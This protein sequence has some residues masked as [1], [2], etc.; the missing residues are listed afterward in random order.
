MRNTIGIDLG[1]TNIAAGAVSPDGRLLSRVSLSTGAD[2]PPEAV[3]ADMA[4]AARAAADQAGLPLSSFLGV[5]VGVP[6]VVDAQAGTVPFLPNLSWRHVP[7]AALLSR[8]LSLPVFLGNDADCAA[9]GEYT[10]GAG[11]QYSSLL[12][13]TLGTGLGGG[14]IHGGRIF[15]GFH[16]E[17]FEPGHVPFRF[18]GEVCG[19]GQRG[20]LEAY[21]SATALIRDTRR[22]MDAHPESALWVHAPSPALVTAK[23]PFDAAAKGDE[24]AEAVL[25]TYAA[26]LAAGLAGLV[27]VLRPEAVALGGG[28]ARQGEVLL[29]LIRGRFRRACFASDDIAPP[30]L[31]CA[32]L[33]NDAGIVGAGLL[34]R[35]V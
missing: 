22:A 15:S 19:C 17:G 13:I 28:V 5:G 1:G 29:S 7:L 8:A 6:G 3:I 9:L 34:P 27:N 11:A 26:Y 2:R 23:T 35:Q 12:L 21:L 14:L 24:T 25:Q 18:G 33:G 4:R 30:A 32:A 20:C 31:V 16:G 10:A